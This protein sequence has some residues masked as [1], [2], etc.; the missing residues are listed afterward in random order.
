[1]IESLKWNAQRVSK[2]CFRSEDF[3]HFASL[4]L[5]QC[6]TSLVTSL[7]Q[8]VDDGFTILWKECLEVL[9]GT[10]KIS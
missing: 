2:Q 9:L 4:T 10:Q 8:S 1:M 7:L 3:A 6:A 5:I